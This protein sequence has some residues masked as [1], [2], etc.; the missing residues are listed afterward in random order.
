MIDTDEKLAVFLPELNAATWIALDTEA[1]SL[2]AYPEKLCLIQVSVQGHDEL[3]DPLAVI[4]LQPLF[5]VLS[6][7]EL[8]MHGADYDL[9]LLRKHCDFVPTAIFDTMLASRLL[10]HREFGLVNLVATHLAVKLEKGPQKANWARRPLTERMA[11]YARHDTH[12]LKPL[13]DILASELKAKGRLSWHQQCC[14]QLI[15]ES[16][17]LREP[18]PD[19]VWRVKGSSALSPRGLAVLR[20]LWHWREQEAITSNRPPFFILPPDAMIRA[21]AG[22]ASGRHPEES[23]PRY[24]TPRRRKGVLKAVANGLAEKHPPGLLP[25]KGHRL[26]ETEKRRLH[27]LEDRR[28]SRAARFGLDPT[29]VASRATLVALASN[30]DKH[31]LELLPWQRELLE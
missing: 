21:A 9:R 22:A 7:H 14:A 12:Y 17:Q 10:G 6:Q 25:R 18:D 27:A 5:E 13:A 4:Q 16:A 15:V 24:L 20:E 2:H 3:I 19:T 28:N 11:N 30:W 26:N 8:I 29:L 1:D 31:K 23:L